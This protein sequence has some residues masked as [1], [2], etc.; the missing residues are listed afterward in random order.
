MDVKKK[1]IL[2]D[3]N[4]VY[5]GPGKW[6]GMWRNRHQLMSRLAEHNRVFY[7]EP[8]SYEVR[9]AGVGGGRKKWIS[10]KGKH[11]YIFHGPVFPKILL[12]IKL[13][14][15]LSV[16]WKLLL[17]LTL[18]RMR[19]SCPIVWV[20]HPDMLGLAKW[21]SGK[22]LVYHIVDEYKA[23]LNVGN[24]GRRQQIEEREEKL[25]RMADIVIV[26]SQELYQS[27]KELNENIYIVRNAVDYIA[28]TKAS[29]SDRHPPADISVI[30]KP[31]IGYTGLISARLD[32]NA[33]LFLAANFPDGNMVLI[34]DVKERNCEDIIKKLKEKKNVH[35]LGMKDVS[36][37]PYYIKEFDVGIIP[38]MFNEE[39]K[40]ADPL[41]LY[42]YFAM[43]KPVVTTK[44]PAANEYRHVIKIAD[45]PT[46]VLQHI[47]FYLTSEETKDRMEERLHVAEQNTWDM[48]IRE[49]SAILMSYMDKVGA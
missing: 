34:G 11:L 48:R 49:I 9:K 23:Y 20:S 18:I 36:E 35:F 30:P 5:F 43:G 47:K 28:F 33:L 16:V 8:Q 42:E 37:I 27:K 39:T 13:R 31:I 10:K 46:E 3:H 45:S 22:V 32:L 26:V 7:I 19:F 21:F 24:Q 12:K 38:Y 2:T 15:F 25:L 44:F 17:K 14:R 40:N 4:L 6:E 1:K 29:T 41:K